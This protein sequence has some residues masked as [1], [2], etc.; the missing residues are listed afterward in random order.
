MP[1]ISIPLSQSARGHLA[2]LGFSFGIAGSFSLGGLVANLISPVALTASRFA[3][4]AMLIAIVVSLDAPLSRDHMRGLW[5]YAVGGMLM[6]MYFVPM[7]VALKTASPV[8]ISTVFTLTPLLSGL[9]GWLLLRQ[10]MTRSMGLALAI[11]ALGAVW[12]IFRGDLA[13][14]QS[15]HI[16]TGEMIFFVGCVAHALYTPFVRKVNR[17]EPVQVFVLGMLISGAVLLGV[18]GWRDIAATP[19]TALPAIVWITMAY[20]TII[21]TAL[22]FLAVSYASLRIPA[23]KVMAY[24]YL[25]PSWVLVWEAALGHGLPDARIIIG[26]VAIIMALLMLLRTES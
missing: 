16:G 21:A 8:S 22:T 23:A 26:F 18:Y 14:M 4:A 7:F 25:T 1:R 24:T 10:R 9:F 3:L 6:A 13:A 2:M 12:V 19:W 17:G 11:G 15:L 5:R 20:L